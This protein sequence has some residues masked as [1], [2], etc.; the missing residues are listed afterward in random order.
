MGKAHEYALKKKG[1]VIRK[2]MAKTTGKTV[3]FIRGV[4]ASRRRRKIGRRRV[5]EGMC[6]SL[7]TPDDPLNEHYQSRLGERKVGNVQKTGMMPKGKTDSYRHAGFEK[8]LN[9]G[10]L[11]MVD[12]EPERQ[13][14]K[15]EEQKRIALVCSSRQH[16][17]E[18]E[19][20]R[21]DVS[22][23]ALRKIEG[24]ELKEQF[25]KRDLAST[26]GGNPVKA[27]DYANGVAKADL[28][29]IHNSNCR[30]GIA[31]I[32]KVTWM[33][34]V[35]LGNEQTNA[36]CAISLEDAFRMALSALL[37]AQLPATLVGKSFAG[38][39]LKVSKNRQQVGNRWEW[40]F[41]T[42][43]GSGLDVLA[44]CGASGLVCTPAYILAA[45][46]HISGRRA[47]NGVCHNPVAVFAV[48]SQ[49]KA[50]EVRKICRP[51]KN[52]LNIHTVC[53]HPGTPLDRQIEGLS[54]MLPE[55]L[56][57]TPDRL[58][59]LISLQ[60]VCVS[61]AS[62]MVVDGLREIM[63]CGFGD[64]LIEL[65]SKIHPC[66]QIAI[67]GD[68]FSDICTALCRKLLRDPIHRVTSDSSVVERSACITQSI[69]VV[70]FDLGRL[71]KLCK[72]LK[73]SLGSKNEHGVLVILHRPDDFQKL[74]ADLSAEGYTVGC[75]GGFQNNS[76]Q[77]CPDLESFRKGELHVLLTTED[78][79]EHIDLS[80][81]K[82]VIN[83]EFPSSIHKYCKI[84]TRMASCTVNG[85][86]HSFC[87][88]STAPF[89]S[90][91]V[92]LLIH[93]SQNVHPSLKML[94]EAANMVQHKKLLA[95]QS[96]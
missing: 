23:D 27:V 38:G 3:D 50:L 31:K 24:D 78:V 26:G 75:T 84:L 32:D 16:S 74:L 1:K 60:A 67:L 15:K 46:V 36:S 70:S 65:R 21:I 48:V 55:I 9:S 22:S 44:T 33:P 88:G 91:L 71:K 49:E 52:A 34:I 82:T 77:L 42:S 62:F 54:T 10:T 64:H 19:D 73:H 92:Q 8:R 89:A 45:A 53:L 35:E 79:I 51:L 87:S 37:D 39:K 81:L 69:D 40:Q 4:Q 83:Y 47:Q 85:T 72:I 96:S 13:R 25:V 56:V 28:V 20:M 43:C 86:L 6:F 41:W 14:L 90:H 18:S 59:R 29:L 5:C 58:Q 57:A 95:L 68:S 94:A 17:M 93:C 2:Q 80:P 11:E 63:A 76:L 30:H 66:A 7:P 12:V 61:N